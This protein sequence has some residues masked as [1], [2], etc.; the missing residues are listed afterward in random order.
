[1]AMHEPVTTYRSSR[2]QVHIDVH[3]G[4]QAPPTFGA[5]DK[6]EPGQHHCIIIDAF[7]VVRQAVDQF[8]DGEFSIALTG[9]YNCPTLL[10]YLQIEFAGN[11]DIQDLALPGFGPG[12]F[13]Y[14]PNCTL[15]VGLSLDRE[16]TQYKICW[17]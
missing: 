5:L 1:M 6:T 9:L 10:R 15:P 2:L 13:T 4:K 17:R 7:D 16:G 3:R 14:S 8:P 11:P 12:R